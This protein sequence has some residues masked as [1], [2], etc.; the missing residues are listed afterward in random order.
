MALEEILEAQYARVNRLIAGVNEEIRHIE[1]EL[2]FDKAN[3]SLEMLLEAKKGELAE[4]K[5]ERLA[6]LRG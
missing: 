5:A 2:V 4:L 1:N 6:I 3:K